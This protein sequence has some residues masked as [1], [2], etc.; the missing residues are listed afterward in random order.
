[1]ERRIFVVRCCGRSVLEVFAND[2]SSHMDLLVGSA[3][4]CRTGGDGTDCG[5]S[6]VLGVSILLAWQIVVVLVVAWIVCCGEMIGGN[7]VAVA[8]WWVG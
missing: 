4:C 1:M 6:G 3:G 7:L 5:L 8:W 2:V